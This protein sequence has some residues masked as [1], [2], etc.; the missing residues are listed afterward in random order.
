MSQKTTFRCRLLNDELRS[1]VLLIAVFRFVSAE[2]TFLAV[3]DY[4]DARCFNTSGHQSTA[5][6]LSAFHS[7]GYVVFRG[8]ALIRISRD[9][10]SKA[11]VSRQNGCV[12]ENRLMS[13]G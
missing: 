10:D 13:F 4:L 1:S 11:R 12:L 3:A 9:R 7:E 8:P 5:S 2:G 6:S